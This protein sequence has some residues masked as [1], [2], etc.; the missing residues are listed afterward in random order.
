MM[1]DEKVGLKGRLRHQNPMAQIAARSGFAPNE[2]PGA[3]RRLIALAKRGRRPQES[4]I[5]AIPQFCAFA[6]ILM[7]HQW[8]SCVCAIEKSA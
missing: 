3:G 8:R 4:A 7:A 1:T 6:R 5:V 2:R